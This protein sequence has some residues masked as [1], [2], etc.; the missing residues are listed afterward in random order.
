VLR[1]LA[2]A[3]VAVGLL[4][5]IALFVL[6][7]TIDL[8]AANAEFTTE[9]TTVYYSDGKHEIGTLAEQ[10]RLSIPLADVPQHVQDAVIAAED[11]SFYDNQG[12]DLAG[13]ARAAFN[14]ARGGDTQGASTIT[15]QYV[16]VLYLTQDQSYTRKLREAVLA[17]KIQQQQS[18]EEVLE[19]YLNT[20]YFGRGAYGIQ[21]AALAFFDRDAKDLTVAQGAVLASVLN[22]PGNL[23]PANGRAARA[24]LAARYDYVLDGMVEMGALDADTAAR[25]Q[26][27]LPVFPDVKEQERYGG[28][29]GHLLRLVEAEMLDAGFQEAEITGGGL[30]IITTFDYKT[31]KASIKAVK[32]ERPRANADGVHIGIAAVE[33]GTGA[34]RA[35]YGGPNYLENSVNYALAGQQPGSSFKPFALAAALQSGFSLRD[36]VTGNT[37]TYPDGSTVSNEFGMSY[38]PAISLL[39]ATAVSSNTG[40]VDLVGQ[41]QNGPEKVIDTAVA[42]GIP[43]NSAALE[44]VPG[45]PLG[46]ADIRPLDMAVAY[47]TF[48]AE[49]EQADWYAI[50]KVDNSNGKLVYEHKV[51]SERA[52]SADVAADVTYA[53][54][55]VVTS[56]T[57]TEALALG[58]PVAGKTGTAALR[59]DT[60]TS[61]WFVGYTPRLAAAV[62]YI[63]GD[64]R[65]DLDGVGGLS[66]FFGGEYPARTFTRF[67]AKAG[68]DQ[69]CADFP[70]PAFLDGNAGT[71]SVAPTT[72]APTTVAP[73]TEAP[74]TEAPTTEAPTTEAP[75][76]E[77][78]TTEAP[79][80]EATT[81]PPTTTQPP[82]ETTKPPKTEPTKEPTETPTPSEEPTQTPTE[83]TQTPPPETPGNG[84]GNGPPGGNGDPP[85]G[86]GD[87]PGGNGDPPGGNGNGGGPPGGNGDPPGGSGN[88]D[89]NGNGSA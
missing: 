47:A 77:A 2:L 79:T 76:T 59:P 28:P 11:R 82:P 22:S 60:V 1:T 67:M 75:T 18:K 58:C 61:A 24:E 34:L 37:Y 36:S 20:V 54:Q 7:R 80:P 43:R 71:P 86:N 29:K 64:G 85:G 30:S 51:T 31:Q 27:S 74:T 89:G 39:Y 35:M 48:A 69:K 5:A 25:A 44:P 45:I 19:G 33:P 10:N 16:K 8:P 41:M 12:I 17:V 40:Y 15:Q 52:F 87:P 23:D 83:P 32:A 4:G 46:T 78:P 13:I 3:L 62:M 42:A 38:G 70:K 26:G 73:T 55:E 65:R 57:G 53:L 68:Q 9:T 66:T 21:A 50:E 56:G 81:P 6:Y 88:A 72:E 84:N 49:G 14:N 63:R